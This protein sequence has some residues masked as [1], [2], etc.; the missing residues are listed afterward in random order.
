MPTGVEALGFPE[1]L[2]ISISRGTIAGASP[3]IK[4]GRNESIDTAND[5]DIWDGGGDYIFPTAAR[6]HDL[7]STDAND[8]DG[9]AGANT[10]Q[11]E[12][13]DANYIE[14]S[15]VVE[16]NGV[17]NV[18]TVNSYLRINRMFVLTAGATGWNEGVITATAQTDGTVSAQITPGQIGNNQT[19]QA[20][21]TVPADKSGCI[22]DIWGSVNKKNAAAAEVSLR[23][24][25]LGGVFRNRHPIG[26]HTT[27]SSYVQHFFP[28]P[29][30]VDEKT[31]LIMRGGTGTNDT[32]LSAGFDLILL[33]NGV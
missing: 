25:P 14:I 16:M 17:A 9:D 22:L 19:Q 3:I 26:I 18:P 29:L 28:L 5:E 31:D 24:R 12:G 10:L 15:E 1:E 4:F 20:I 23:F 11:V 7:A 13:L 30:L 21:Y 33:A 2:L 27:G 8:A 6:I 32:D